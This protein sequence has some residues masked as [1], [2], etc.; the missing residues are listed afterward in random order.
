MFT[1]KLVLKSHPPHYH[2]EIAGEFIRAILKAS[3]FFLPE[4]LGAVCKE[5]KRGFIPAL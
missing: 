4:N 3:V 2:G 5:K 1:G